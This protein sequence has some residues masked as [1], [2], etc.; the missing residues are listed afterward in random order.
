MKVHYDIIEAEELVKKCIAKYGCHPEQNLE[1][2]K[3]WV[4]EG[5]ECVFFD[6]GA[7]QGLIAHWHPAAKEWIMFTEPMALTKNRQK[8]FWQFVDYIFERKK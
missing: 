2:Y 4:D 6:F 7:H 3:C 8:L 5:D 1:H